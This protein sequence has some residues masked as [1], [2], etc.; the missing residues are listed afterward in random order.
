MAQFSYR[1][2]RYFEIVILQLTFDACLDSSGNVKIDWD[3]LDRVDERR[4]Q[5]LKII[6]DLERRNF[7]FRKQRYDDT[8]VMPW[9]RNQDS[10]QVW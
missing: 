7:V 1:C 2:S 4:N 3:F 10:P 5:E 6:P 8:V 9:Y